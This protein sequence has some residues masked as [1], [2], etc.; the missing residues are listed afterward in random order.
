MY[1]AK[2][3]EE[4]LEHHRGQREVL[5]MLREIILETEL[6]ETLKWGA[7][8]YVLEGKHVVGLGAF[9]AYVG[10]WFHQGVFLKDEAGVLINAQE[11]KTKAL[12]QWRFQ[13]K[14]EVN[15]K[16][17]KA[18]VLEAIENQKQG[19]EILPEKKK[20]L[21]IPPELEEAFGQNNTL[22]VAFEKLNLTKRREFAEYIAEAK[23]AT[24]KATRL[25]KIIPMILE[26]VGLNDKY[27]G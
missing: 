5:E 2:S 7:P 27:R 1:M 13:S 14:E 19:R 6:E 25:E 22:A 12:R 24:T 3:V 4:Y 26:G 21:E 11:G 10:L 8:T 16:K 20:P 23:R 9:K 15:A 17:V 18:Y